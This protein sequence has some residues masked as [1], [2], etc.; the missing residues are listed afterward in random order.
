[1]V[2][3]GEIF[4]GYRI[5]REVGRGGMGS[6]FVARDPRLPR[7][8]ALKLLHRE[9]FGD[10]E[11]RKRFEL[12]AEVI[13]QLDH[14]N[15]ITVHDRGCEDDQLWIAMQYVNGTDCQ[16][17]EPEDVSPERAVQIILQTAAALDYAH[18][19][20]ILHR[21]VKPAN[22]LLSATAGF[23]F[24]ERVLLTDFGIARVLGA[25]AHQRLTTTGKLNATLAYASPEQLTAEQLDHRSDQYSLA[26]TL[27][28][29]LTGRAPFESPMVGAVVLGHV[30]A[31]PPAVTSLRA[32]LPTRLDEVLARALAKKP[33]ERYGSCTEFAEAAW[34]AIRTPVAAGADR[35]PP[36]WPERV[37]GA[38]LGGAV[39]DA[40]GAPV[41]TML[42][43]NIQQRFG[44]Q[45]VNGD[46]DLYRG[47][48]S[49]E[50]QMTLFTTEALIR[51]SVRVR[52]SMH[53]RARG[54]G[55]AATGLIQESLLVWLGG[56][57]IAVAAQPYPLRSS[58][59]MYPEL[60][61]Y[62]GPTHA[63]VSAM[64]RVAALR[65]PGIA[66]GTREQP[67]NDSKGCAA[68]VR[69]A[70]CGFA[71]SMA[72]AFELGCDSGA[73][74]HGNP[75]GWLPA[76]VFAATVFGLSAGLELRAALEQA[77]IELVRHDGHEETAA[78]L[79]AAVR[80][81]GEQAVAGGPMPEPDSLEALG[82]GVIGTEAL[83]IAVYSALCAEVIGGADEQVFRNGV[84]LSVN[85]SGDSDATGSLCGALL[86]ARLGVR[87]VPERWRTPLDATAVIERLSTDFCR[88]FG[89]HPPQDADG[90]P[91]D[92][93]YARYPG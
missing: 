86:G 4:A 16:T 68:V 70:P 15:V 19:K 37:H 44:I 81:A 20:G 74:T 76:G 57:G 27:F 47:R 77:R 66:L 34:E 85:H 54:L 58:L 48:I 52:S 50:T 32:G 9:M 78:A 64:E 41:E 55:V 79:D 42:L 33:Q 38:L 67:I 31:Q 6:V 17:L 2:R 30:Q 53:A 73:L 80:L 89:D 13:A 1:M 87:A 46:P 82:Y 93:W 45:G 91:P 72:E 65:R 5:E 23:G 62:R 10:T 29:L 7:W 8:I 40:L 14:P 3:R 35:R 11:T 56:Q 43:R 24:N 61:S 88:E 18:G 36:T 21:D 49:D 92:E 39:G 69:S 59:T 83:A 28:R 26:C 63:T 84:L 25:S 12:E 75:S 51:G 60:M 22:I 71:R 90:V